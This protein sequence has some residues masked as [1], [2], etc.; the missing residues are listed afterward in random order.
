MDLPYKQSLEDLVLFA[1][2]WDYNRKG[3][4]EAKPVEKD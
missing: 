1:A 3:N 2:V 4:L